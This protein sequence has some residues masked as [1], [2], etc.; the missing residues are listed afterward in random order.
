MVLEALTI[1]QLKNLIE[2]AKRLVE[3]KQPPT[4]E[5]NTVGKLRLALS[6]YPDKMPIKIEYSYL[7][8]EETGMD[9][10]YD[11]IRLVN[12]ETRLVITR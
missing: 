1:E 6:I 7:V 12:L 9:T 5:I 2:N 3:E 8:S 10:D 11:D 4:A